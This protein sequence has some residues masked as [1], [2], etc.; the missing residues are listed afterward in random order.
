MEV[1]NPAEIPY[2]RGIFP[3]A[4]RGKITRNCH[5]TLSTSP[6]TRGMLSHTLKTIAVVQTFSFAFSEKRGKNIGC[7]G[8]SPDDVAKF[9]G[10]LCNSSST[11]RAD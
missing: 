1:Y 11:R 6:E 7:I 2:G 4:F 10:S 3:D 5:A 8:V 9:L